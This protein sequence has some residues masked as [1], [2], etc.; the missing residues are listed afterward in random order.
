MH[1]EK[2]RNLL[3]IYIQAQTCRE[4]EYMG[5]SCPNRPILI[6]YIRIVLKFRVYS[7]EFDCVIGRFIYINLNL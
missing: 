6:I 3:Y 2:R 1:E 4:Q 7:F 5:V